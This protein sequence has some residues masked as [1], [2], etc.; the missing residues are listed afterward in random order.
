[1]VVVSG[2]SIQSGSFGPVYRLLMRPLP[3]RFLQFFD[4]VSEWISWIVPS[5]LRSLASVHFLSFMTVFL[6]AVASGL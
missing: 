3:L 4:P 5:G 2:S 1:M 6:V